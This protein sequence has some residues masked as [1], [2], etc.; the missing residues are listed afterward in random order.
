MDRFSVMLATRS[1]GDGGDA[2]DLYGCGNTGNDHGVC[3]SACNRT[4]CITPTNGFTAPITFAAQGF[5]AEST[6]AF[7]P[8]SVTPAGGAVT[9]TMTITTTA[10]TVAANVRPEALGSSGRGLC[11]SAL[12]DWRCCIA[13]SF[14]TEGPVGDGGAGRDTE[15]WFAAGMRGQPAGQF[16]NYRGDARRYVDCYDN[17]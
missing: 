2:C 7:A 3:G 6:C 9:T 8:K 14:P 12:Q 17:G 13:A 11:G 15:R 5:A 1:G 16:G 4:Q 10:G